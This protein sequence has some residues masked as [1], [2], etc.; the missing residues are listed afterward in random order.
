MSPMVAIFHAK[1][2]DPRSGKG[3]IQNESSLIANTTISSHSKSH[4]TTDVGVK[5]VLCN[6]Q[7]VTAD[8]CIA[9]S[10][11]TLYLRTHGWVTSGVYI[12]TPYLPRV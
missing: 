3:T 7:V 12:A 2:S 5:G 10:I 4:T 1:L 9:Q 11:L 6:L 8:S